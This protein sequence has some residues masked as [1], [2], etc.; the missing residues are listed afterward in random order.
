VIH[1]GELEPLEIGRFHYKKHTLEYYV[2][3]KGRKRLGQKKWQREVE[4]AVAR[5]IEVLKPSDTVLGGGNVKKLKALPRGTRKGDNA[6]AFIGG[7]RLW[8]PGAARPRPAEPDVNG[9]SQRD[10]PDRRTTSIRR[11]SSTLGP[12]ERPQ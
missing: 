9:A 10:T 6:F 1:D 7:F 11:G 4:K 2:G 3:A 12:K 8:E 5:L